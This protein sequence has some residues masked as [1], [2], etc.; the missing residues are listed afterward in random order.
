MG[1]LLG[2]L[3]AGLAEWSFAAVFEAAA[4]RW[5]GRRFESSNVDVVIMAVVVGGLALVAVLVGGFGVPTLLAFAVIAVPVAWA[6][7]EVNK[8][9]WGDG[10]P[11]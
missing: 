11:P 7:H 3:L 10:N 2:F 4:G 8:R 9:D 6:I 5:A 1:E